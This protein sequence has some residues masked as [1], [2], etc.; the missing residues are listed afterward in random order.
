[1]NWLD[2]TLAAII[3]LF[4]LAGFWKGLVSQI[5][6]TAALVG[7]IAVGFLFYDVLG[8]LLLKE[9]FL[10]NESLAN[11]LGFTVLLLAAYTIIQTA[12]WITA[13]LIGTLRLSWLNRTCGGALGAVMGA[14][15]AFLLSSCLSL[16]YPQDDPAFKGSLILPYLNE[17]ALAAKDALPP[18]LEKSFNEAKE[19]VREEGLRAAMKIKD[20]DAVKEILNQNESR[21]E[22]EN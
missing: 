19:L 5:F 17:A 4:T 2:M 14:A 16:F 15:T 7:G 18:D 8:D 22:K 21:Q 12:G 20:S 13:K 3:A 9:K 11:V 10:D 1:M 6:S